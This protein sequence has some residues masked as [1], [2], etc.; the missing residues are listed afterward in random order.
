MN[1]TTVLV[2]II[3]EVLLAGAVFAVVFFV[4]SEAR[5]DRKEEHIEKLISK[6]FDKLEHTKRTR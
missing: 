6:Q 5:A 2:F 3:A 4:I 1:G